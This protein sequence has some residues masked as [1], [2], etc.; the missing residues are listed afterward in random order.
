LEKGG[1]VAQTL[2]DGGRQS[3]LVEGVEMQAGGAVAQE[4]AAHFGYHVQ[5]QRFDGGGV[6]GIGLQLQSQP[7]RNFGAAHIGEAGQ[8]GEVGNRHDAGHDGDFHAAPAHVV[9]EAEVGIG[10]EE[11]LGDGGIG[12][13]FHFAHEALNVVFGAARLRVVFRVGGH[14]DVEPVAES[15]ADEFHQFV[16]VAQAGGAQ[17]HAGGDVAAQG[18]HMADA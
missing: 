16:G 6:V 10:V 15:V 1:L 11:K 8:L 18:K 13:G 9:E 3:G 17:A 12:T 14:F 4:A 5:P 2:A 7:A